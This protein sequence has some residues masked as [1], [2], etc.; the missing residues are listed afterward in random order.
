M[1]FILF[2]M[3]GVVGNVVGTLV[4]GG[5]LISLPTMLLMGLPVHSA[6]GANKV[7]N[8]VSSLI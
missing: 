6:I 5:G 3:V 8:T 2:F 7:S 4:G 1:E